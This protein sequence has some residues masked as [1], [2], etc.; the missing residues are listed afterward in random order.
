[1][2]LDG[3]PK[4]VMSL[5]PTDNPDIVPATIGPHQVYSKDSNEM[6]FPHDVNH[7]KWYSVIVLWNGEGETLEGELQEFWVKISKDRKTGQWVQS[8]DDITLFQR[9]M[10]Y[11]QITIPPTPTP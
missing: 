1:L 7:W 8:M 9:Q 10:T 5:N 3:T 2:N 11:S 4:R 6:G